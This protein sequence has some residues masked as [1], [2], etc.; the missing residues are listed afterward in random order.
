MA[1]G[2]FTGG[3]VSVSN[4][5]TAVTGSATT[6]TQVSVGATFESAGHQVTIASVESDTALTLA[7][8]W[9]GTTLADA[10]GYL[11]KPV[12]ESASLALQIA[13]KLQTLLDALSLKGEILDGEGA[14]LD[15]L[16]DDGDAYIDTT[17]ARLYLKD[18]GAWSANAISLKGDQGDSLHIDAV[19]LASA[20]STY[21]DEAALF[22]FMAEDTGQIAIKRSATSADWS[23]WI[24]FQGPQGVQGDP[25]TDGA[26]GAP[27][28]DGADGAVWSAGTVPGDGV[29]ADGDFHLTAAGQVYEKVAGTWT[30]TGLNLTGPQGVQGDPGLDGADG[31]TGPQGD[32]GLSFDPDAVG[33]AADRSTYD[34]E[35]A[36]FAFLATDTNQVSWKNSATSGDWSAWADWG[37]VSGASGAGSTTPLGM[38]VAASL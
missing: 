1:L 37:G 24:D 4:G 27:G 25:G 11:L 30:D 32:P 13:L 17:G 6:F 21:D 31:G 26:D 10:S 36:L 5:G 35:A 20:R 8:G 33:L 12:A 2:Y 29:G 7:L 14:P 38:F 16:G 3:T 22:T 18:S 23:A 28:A 15:S 19:G 34:S 9:P